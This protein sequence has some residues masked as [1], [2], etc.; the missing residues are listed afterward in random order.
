VSDE[1]GGVIRIE[2]TFAAPAEAVF[3]AW[4]NPEV[5]RD[6]WPLVAKSCDELSH[7]RGSN[8]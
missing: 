1:P 7:P 5:M 6:Q 4:T 8:G 2:R 3:D